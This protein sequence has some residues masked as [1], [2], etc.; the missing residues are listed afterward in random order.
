MSTTPLTHTQGASACSVVLGNIDTFEHIF[1][2]VLCSYTCPC[3]S[4]ELSRIAL[5]C[6][7]FLE[8]V[9]DYTW[10]T[11]GSLLPLLK[12]LPAFKA[13]GS[14][15]GIHGAISEGDWARFD[16]YAR[17]VRAMRISKVD[18]L[19]LSASA[20]TRLAQLRPNAFLPALRQLSISFFE[21]R[22]LPW[23]YLCLSPT[24]DSVSVYSPRSVP[25]TW[26]GFF[27]SA[28]ADN[29]PTLSSLRVV[30]RK[31][32][33][34]ALFPLSRFGNLRTLDIKPKPCSDGFF[35]QIG[36]LTNLTKLSIDLL[37]T[38]TNLVVIHFDSLQELCISS[39]FDIISD[40]LLQ[41][42]APGL[43]C[44]EMY[45]GSKHAKNTHL[46]NV[47]HCLSTLGR[48][49]PMLRELRI[50]GPS[51]SLPSEETANIVDLLKQ[52]VQLQKFDIDQWQGALI[53][54]G[55]DILA[56]TARW[57]KIK[58]LSFPWLMENRNDAVTLQELGLL[59]SRCPLL[60]Y[61]QIY[62]DLSIIPPFV[63]GASTLSQ[64]RILSVGNRNEIKNIEEMLKVARYL[65]HY[66]R[67]L[68]DIECHDLHDKASWCQVMDVIRMF[69]SI[70]A[71][72]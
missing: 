15:Y 35:E 9:L 61:L 34:E 14:D 21:E 62:L 22:D 23:L 2:H 42:T 44:F 50:A 46:R 53:L 27:L 51:D 59:A 32:L 40:V 5:V 68:D 71:N 38:P 66:F 60:D 19:R 72:T 39:S 48:R 18:D 11:L 26:I 31:S 30:G 36:H 65:D 54:S 55:S 57:S 29:A 4:P 45:G 47:G 63:S 67:F 24:L 17:R 10:L 7:D 16:Y 69:Q 58:R 25:T 13:L 6:K 43:L 37:T 20:S 49:W 33:D 41:I 1:T 64:L 52:L 8:K 3:S 56:V 28:L 70:R 12:I